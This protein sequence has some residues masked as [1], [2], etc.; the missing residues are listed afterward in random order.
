[1]QTINIISN[2]KS[3]E[4]N[5]LRERLYICNT[6]IKTKIYLSIL[7]LLIK[8]NSTLYIFSMLYL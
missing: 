1:M 6:N 4:D 7:Y 8:I 5:I 3:F 2:N